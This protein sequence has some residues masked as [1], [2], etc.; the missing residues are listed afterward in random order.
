MSL[1]YKSSG[2]IHKDFHGL[3]CATLHYLIDNYGEETLEI[4]VRRF[5]QE[6]YKTIHEGLKND[7]V[8]ELIEFWRYYFSREGGDFVIDCTD[9]GVHLEV[10][11]CPVLSH[12]VKIR[13]KSDS[14]ICEATKLFNMFITEGSSYVSTLNKTGEFSC[15]QIIAKKK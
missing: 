4:I 13:R 8:T 11:N 12:L 9:E 14:I 10:R 15:E 3:T 1:R 6:V 5:A 2:E 7:D